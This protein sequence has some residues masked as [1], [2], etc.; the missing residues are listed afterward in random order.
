MFRSAIVAAGSAAV[1]MLAATA[2][3]QQ[4]DGTADEAKAMLTKTVSALKADKAK[5]IDLINEGEVILIATC[6]RSASTSATVRALRVASTNSKQTLGMDVI[7]R[8][9]T[10]LHGVQHRQLPEV[11]DFRARLITTKSELS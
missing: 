4:D 9:A 6:I 7:P 11:S 2:F 8:I 10:A 5:T 3:A 1:L